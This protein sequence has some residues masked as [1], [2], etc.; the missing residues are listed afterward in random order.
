ME[1][2]SILL[3]EVIILSKISKTEKDKYMLSLHMWNLRKGKEK[4]ISEK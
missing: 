3:H 2:N 1:S 4:L